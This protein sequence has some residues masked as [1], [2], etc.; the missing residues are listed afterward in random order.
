MTAHEVRVLPLK[1][2]AVTCPR[3][4]TLYYFLTL[5]KPALI[6]LRK[7]LGTVCNQLPSIEFFTLTEINLV[8]NRDPQNKGV[9]WS[10][11]CFVDNRDAPLTFPTQS[12]GLIE[13]NLW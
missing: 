3:H 4:L 10:N 2:N 6:E 5:C 13:G 8:D 9:L 12:T 11:L 1:C 7:I